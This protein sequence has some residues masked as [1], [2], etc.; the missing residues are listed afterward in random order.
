[1]WRYDIHACEP[2][3]QHY[4]FTIANI[5]TC[6]EP[7]YVPDSTAE[8]TTDESPYL[9]LAQICETIY[10]LSEVLLRGL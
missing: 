9:V 7:H 1:M 5:S 3:S 4:A 10:L 2:F 6:V 8:I